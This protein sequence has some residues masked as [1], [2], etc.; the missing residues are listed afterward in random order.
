[1]K[2]ILIC[3]IC[4]L[5]ISFALSASTIDRKNIQ[6]LPVLLDSAEYDLF[7]SDFSEQITRNFI[8]HL[9]TTSLSDANVTVF[10][11][12]L[13]WQSFDLFMPEASNRSVVFGIDVSTD[14]F[15]KG[16]L[17]VNGIDRS[18]LY[19]DGIKQ[20]GSQ[21]AYGL[22][23]KNAEYQFFVIANGIDSWDDVSFSWE[24]ANEDEGIKF[25]WPTNKKRLSAKQMYD[26]Q[27]IGNLHISPDAEH[28]I[29]TKSHYSDM[30]SET[31]ADK[32]FS[33]TELLDVD[34]QKVLYRWQ[35]T[36]PTGFSWSPDN[37]RLLFLTNNTLFQLD[38]KTFELKKV[39]ENLK[40]AGNFKWLSDNKVVFN[41]RKPDDTEP[42]KAK[43]YLALEDRWSYWR[44]NTQIYQL[45]VHAGYV[46]QLTRG[47]TSHTLTDVNVSQNKILATRSLVDY[48]KPPHFAVEAVEIALE[49]RELKQ[50]TIHNGNISQLLYADDGYYIVAGPTFANRIGSTLDKETLDNE[51]DG[52]LF[53]LSNDGN[54]TALSKTFNPAITSASAIAENNLLITA[55]D[56]DRRHLFLFDK[57]NDEFTKLNSDID[58]VTDVSVSAQ[59]HPTVLIG[60]TTATK[61]SKVIL[62]APKTKPKVLFNS[63]DTE[64]VNTHFSEVRDWVFTNQLGEK[65][66]GRYYLPPDFDENKKYPMIVYYYGGT[67]PVSRAFTGRWPFSLW[68]AKG[69]IVYIMQPAGTIGYG[70]AF[71]SKHVN[72]WGIQTADDIITSTKA[73]LAAHPF[74]DASKVANMGASYGGFMTMYLATKTDLFAASISHAGISNLSEYWGYGWWGFSY[75]GIATRGK[76]PWNATDFYTQQ[77]PLFQADK[78]TTP[79]LLIHG[80]SDTNVPV[81]QSHQ[82]Y[83]ALKLLGKDV[84]LVEF[85]GED[86]HINS[87][88]MRFAWW[89]TIL[90]YLDDKLKNQPLWWET[91]YPGPT[92]D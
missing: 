44:N 4:P 41:W 54:I 23:L 20:D 48:S 57:S 27:T 14:R 85:I 90:S 55:V 61:P 42:K 75:S 73:F 66:D 76:F 40:G 60:G 64:Y 11:E 33:M 35:D 30:G 70:Q 6:V 72:A 56:K 65:I 5:F 7:D 69:Y 10:G 59:T 24:G 91:L 83:T 32:P 31:D 29:W 88:E 38:R 71:S 15:T 62:Q 86:H 1:M 8:A 87:R 80:D 74:V 18:L 79:L 39:A 45:D 16:T 26:S 9:D 3:F 2:K 81:S 52:Q 58:V 19:I 77:S 51:Y 12:D 34:S 49:T 43:R 63:E 37:S 25:T 28:M 17:T 68:A 22:T 50:L 82:M 53:Y 89:D 13:K 21:N 36:T 84:E 46:Q 92:S 78:V 67:T 47:D